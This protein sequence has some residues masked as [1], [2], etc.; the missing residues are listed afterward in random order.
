LRLSALSRPPRESRDEIV[1][2]H[3]QQAAEK[4]LKVEQDDRRHEDGQE[5][6]R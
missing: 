2:F 5:H 3:G 4:L 6:P 1:G